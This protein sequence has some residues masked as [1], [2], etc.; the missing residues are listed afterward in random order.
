MLRIALHSTGNDP[1]SFVL[2]AD[3]TFGNVGRNTLITPAFQTFDVAI[4]KRITMPF[5][6]NHAL[7][8]RLEAFNVFNHPVW[9]APNGNITSGQFGVITSTAAAVNMRQLQ[10]GLKYS[11]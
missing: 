5:N 10:V 2:A 8:L 11:F 1:A 6:E 7:Q 3:G 9:N 4:H